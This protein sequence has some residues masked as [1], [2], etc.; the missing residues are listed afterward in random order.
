MGGLHHVRP[1]NPLTVH[2]NMSKQALYSAFIKRMAAAHEARQY[3]ESSWYA[4]TVLEDRLRS[5]LRSTGGE[6]VGG[7]GKPIRMMGPKLK[8]LKYRAKKDELL[9]ANFEHDRLNAWKE[10]RNNL[11][12]AMA[13]ASMTLAQIDQGAE[14]LSIEGAELVRVFSAACRRVKKH[15][16]KVAT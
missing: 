4:Y 12:H 16:E 1:R 14:R 5:L 15:R 11:M 6:G 2:T 3:F 10:D 9:K 13:D 7:P 8:E